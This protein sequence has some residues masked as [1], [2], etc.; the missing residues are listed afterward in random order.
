MNLNTL[1]ILIL[2]VTALTGQ[3][4]FIFIALVLF[5][6]VNGYACIVNPDYRAAFLSKN[7]KVEVKVEDWK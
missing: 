4:L 5:I 3:P 2:I 1:L 7:G 6:G